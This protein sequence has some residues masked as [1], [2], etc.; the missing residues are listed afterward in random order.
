MQ[1]NILN[2]ITDEKEDSNFNL[3]FLSAIYMYKDAFT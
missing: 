2:Q 3:S 1:E